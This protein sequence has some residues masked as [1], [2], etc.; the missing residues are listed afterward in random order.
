M[1]IAEET[2]LRMVILGAIRLWL[3]STVS[4]ASGIPWP[5]MAGEP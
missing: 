1:A 3:K 5:R 4:M 2:G